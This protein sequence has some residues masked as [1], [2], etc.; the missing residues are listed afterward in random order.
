M[1]EKRQFTRVGFDASA[2][3]ICDE[4]D[5]ATH[6]L[7]ISL[8]GAL[9]RQP[10]GAA[11]LRLNDSVELNLLLSDEETELF[12]RGHI[13]H[14][15]AGHIGIECEHLDV[16]SASHLRRLI[17]LNTGS[18]ALLERELEALIHCHSHPAS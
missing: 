15:E 16:D 11:N 1:I 9:I 5:W 12:M 3:L 10:R 18:E 17:E 14:L 6:L 13:A 8:K 2:R 7:D 4:Q